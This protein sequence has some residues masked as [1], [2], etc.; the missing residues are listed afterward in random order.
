MND[1]LDDYKC[2][3]NVTNLTQLISHVI[4]YFILEHKSELNHY[5]LSSN[6]DTQIIECED[7][8]FEIMFTLQNNSNDVFK[9]TVLLRGYVPCYQVTI[10]N[11]T[12]NNL[13]IKYR[14]SPFITTNV[15]DCI[16]EF[17]IYLI[18]LIKYF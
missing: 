16:Y 14:V 2:E 7:N 4:S 5:Y 17:L 15:Y 18:D 8:N 9:T 11:V 3:L 12:K 6:I 13:N 10:L 1:N